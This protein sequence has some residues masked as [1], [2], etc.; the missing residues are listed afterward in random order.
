MVKPLAC[1]NGPALDPGLVPRGSKGVGDSEAYDR[2]MKT[3][4][5]EISTAGPNSG[6]GRH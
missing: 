6:R 1:A 3:L 4:L 5:E 2:A